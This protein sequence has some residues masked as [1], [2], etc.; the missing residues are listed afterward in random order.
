MPGKKLMCC[1]VLTVLAGACVPDPVDDDSVPSFDPEQNVMG[2]IQQEGVLRV[3]VEDAFAPWSSVDESGAGSGLTADLAAL[4]AESLGVEIEFIAAPTEAMG[5]MVTDGDV[6]L[7]F[8]MEP[9][10]EESLENHAWSDPYWVA[11]ARLLVTNDSPVEKVTDLGGM[12]VCEEI[13][14]I[15][16]PETAE[17]NDEATVAG[18]DCLD[19]LT[20][21]GADA[22]LGPDV[23]LIHHMAGADGLKLVGDE[24]S[25]EGYS[26]ML[27]LGTG[28]FATFVDSVFAEADREGRW[29]DLYER[30][31]TPATGL[32][33]PAHP[34]MTLEEA[35]ALFPASG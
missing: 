22:L 13:N 20:S 8:P 11:H 14:E 35:A 12:T 17:L 26:A 32:P 9:I 34:N 23:T 27:A 5:E 31:I 19:L 6:H 33:P 15:T 16:E 1:L 29:S 4:V 28:G 21:G 24:L 18:G 10:T 2:Q 7:A 3:A 25:T 30:W